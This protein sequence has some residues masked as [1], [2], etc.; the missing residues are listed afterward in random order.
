MAPF[1]LAS[2]AGTLS[3]DLIF[4]LL[5]MG[6]GATLEMSGFGDSRKLAAQFYLREMTVLKVMFTGIVTAAT[7]IFLASSFELL[8]FN[9][10]WVN[11]TYLA[12][13]IVG[14][15]IMGVGFI[16]GGFC[17][18]TSVVAASTLKI[19][20]IFFLLGVGFGVFF[21]GESVQNFEDF[22]YSTSM[23]RFT[24]PEWLGL[25]YGVVLLLLVLM[26]LAMFKGAEISEAYFGRGRRL[27][28]I[29]LLPALNPA[30]LAAAVLLLLAL[31]V[32]LKGQP[33]I[34]DRWNW[35]ANEKEP[36][37]KNREVYVDPAEVVE[38][39]K[40]IGVR[41]EIIDLRSEADFNL[42]HISESRRIDATTANEADFVRP[43]LAASDNTVIFLV[44]NGEE[45]A[46]EVWR[47][48]KAQG[49]VNLYI[50]EGG[51]NGW[52][53]RYPLPECLARRKVKAVGEELA[54]EFSYSVGERNPSAHPFIPRI[55][56]M[57]DCVRNQ[58]ENADSPVKA[59]YYE[60]ETEHILPEKKV[61]LTK[62]TV[63][64]GGCG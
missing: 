9:R 52:L 1:N 27:S 37:L 47:R 35:I 10:V 19:D 4:L 59:T 23:G 33:T 57:P 2:L 44:S 39:K 46:T 11:P 62:K 24:I 42:F 22:F 32:A 3:Y 14:G 41:V 13:G 30:T 53:E 38:L 64:K 16:I 63:A 48:L 21:F 29:R 54:Y 18:G 17:P 58:I 8:D 51:I 31:V 60:P 5:G 6:F 20:G 28:E 7:L 61:K 34:E 45:T 50:V 49:V 25:P 40:D 26:A 43:L 56:E 36:L 15:L 55:D 12:P